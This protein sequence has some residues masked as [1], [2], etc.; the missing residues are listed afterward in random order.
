MPHQCVR[1]GTIYQD[2]SS[3]ILTGCS[4]GARLFFYVRKEALEK[5]K[6]VT[7]QLTPKERKQVE[8]DVLDMVH[9]KDDAP[10]V[11][12]FESIRVTKPGKFELDLVQLFDSEN[13]L[14][15]RLEDGKYVIDVAE[16]FARK[17]K[18]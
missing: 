7:E 4:C 2:G 3:E 14:I 13:P 18:K 15:Y 10:V 9:A 17:G 1:C 16:T 6:E 11:L 5:A 12:D 8:K